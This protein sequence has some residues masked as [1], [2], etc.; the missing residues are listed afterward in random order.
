MIEDMLI[1][2]FSLRTQIC[3]ILGA[4]EVLIEV[5]AEDE[6]KGEESTAP[7]DGGHG[8]T[9]RVRL[10]DVALVNAVQNAVDIPVLACA[11]PVATPVVSDSVGAETG[12]GVGTCAAAGVVA[13]HRHDGAELARQASAGKMACLPC[14][15]WCRLSIFFFS[16]S[17]TT[18]ACVLLVLQCSSGPGRAVWS[19]PWC[20]ALHTHSHSQCRCQ[21]QESNQQ[22]GGTRTVDRSLHCQRR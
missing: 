16:F 11:P 2:G 13:P 6:E 21:C 1:Y 5:D 17:L 12:A 14:L 7:A 10:Y 18:Y 9:R 20:G 15:L 8:S 3:E 19:C 22:Q 4:G